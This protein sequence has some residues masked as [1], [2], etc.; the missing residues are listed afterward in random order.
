MDMNADQATKLNNMA[1]RLFNEH[2]NGCTLRDPLNCG[3][4]DHQ[5]GGGE[6]PSYAAW[7]RVYV[8]AEKTIPEK[9][10]MAF[11]EELVSTNKE[12]REALEESVNYFGVRWSK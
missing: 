7:A 9:W 4:C 12:Y 11:Y 10:R 6:G 3:S 1:T 2:Y 5:T 8:E